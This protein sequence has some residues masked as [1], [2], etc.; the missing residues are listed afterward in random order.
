MDMGAQISFW[1]TDFISL[2]MHSTVE[3]LDHMVALFLV[4]GGTSTLFSL[5]AAPIYICANSVWGL[6]FLHT[7]TNT[8]LFD[9]IH[10][11][12]CEVVSHC[13]FDLYFPDD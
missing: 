4:F 10:S 3:L 6:P 13:G 8:C 5:V 1:D 9:N 2:E 11:D 7:L 12:W